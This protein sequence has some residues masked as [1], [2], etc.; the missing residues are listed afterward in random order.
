MQIADTAKIL[1]TIQ[2][3]DNRKVDEVVIRAW[4]AI[5]EPYTF[6]DCFTAV[7]DHYTH[8]RAWMMPADVVDRVKRMGDDRM[9]RFNQ[10]L[11]LRDDDEASTL[12]T[13]AWRE[14][15]RA[16]TRAARNGTLTPETYTA[17]QDGRSEL[18]AGILPKELTQ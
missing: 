11:R 2:T 13:P 18:P 4:H 14:A 6:D 15:V 8:N 16:L 5:L 12:G 1:T 10:G 3:F 17:Y 9:M 7:K